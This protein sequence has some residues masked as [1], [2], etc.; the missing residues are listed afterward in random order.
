[1]K[2]CPN[3]K[4]KTS[5]IPNDAKFCPVCGTKI[6]SFEIDEETEE[7]LEEDNHHQHSSA[8]ILWLLGIGIAFIIIIAIMQSNEV[9]DEDTM[10]IAIFLTLFVELIVGVIIA[11]SISRKK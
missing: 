9:I 6:D 1:M 3:P 4:C 10:I 11:V 2:T 8:P 5:S 7:T